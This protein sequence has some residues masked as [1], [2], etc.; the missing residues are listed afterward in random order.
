MHSQLPRQHLLF[1]DNENRPNEG[2]ICSHWY[3]YLVQKSIDQ[4]SKIGF[5]KVVHS[6]LH[7]AKTASIFFRF[8]LAL[9]SPRSVKAK[10][11]SYNFKDLP[12]I[13]SL[14]C[15][16][17]QQQLSYSVSTHVPSSHWDRLSVDCE[18]CPGT[19]RWQR[20]SKDR[21]CTVN[22]VGDMWRRHY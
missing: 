10:R 4:K 22:T 7:L 9:Y 11:V 8:K 1:T 13:L 12:D 6:V 17:C 5:K 19:N 20:G 16:G 18:W 15:R 21:G 2:L 3:S 14:P